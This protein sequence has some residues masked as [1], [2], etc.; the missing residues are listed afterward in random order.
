MGHLKSHNITYLTGRR[1]LG[2]LALMVIATVM[3]L[4]SC[5][6]TRI[7]QDGEYRLAKNKVRITNDKSFNPS[8]ITPYIKQAPNSY[9][10]GGWNPFLSVWNWQNGKGKGWDKFVKK[11]GVEPVIFDSTMVASSESNITK[12]LEYLG[13]Y[14]SQVTS[15]IIRK[16][17]KVNVEYDVTLGKRYPIKSISI[18]VPDE[19]LREHLLKDSADMMI[20]P[21][22]WLSE[23]LL[24]EETA[25]SAA[26]LRNEGF[27]GFNKNYYFFEADTLACRDSAILN[28]TVENY[29]RNESPS[30]AKPHNKFRINE[31]T[32][33]YPENLKIRN[34]LL[35]NLNTLKPG[36]LYN[37]KNVANTY[38]RLSS[39][40]MFNSVN[41]EMTQ[42]GDSLVDCAI[43]LTPSKMQGF[44]VNAEASVNSTGLIGISP[45]LNY[46]HK[47]IFH[48]GEW[49]NLGFM[50]NF[51]F[52]V[53][54]KVH[55]NEF[56]VSAGISFPRFLT[57]PS[58]FFKGASL[59][60]T[61]IN[62]SYNY[63]SRPE[64][65]RNMISAAYG[66]QGNLKSKFFYQLYPVQLNIVNLHNLD[67]SFFNS[68]KDD[69]FMRN[70]YQNH[71]DLG[72]GGNLY[73]TTNADVKP[74]SSFFYARL[75]LDLAG[76]FL[77]AF[78]KLMDKNESG[79]GMIWNTPYSQFVRTEV[80]V[81]KTWIFGHNKNQSIA[82]RLTAGVGYSYGNSKALPF[83]KHFYVGGA[84]SLRGWQARNVGP[85]LSQR[86]TTFIIP[87][88]T[89]DV[90]LEANIEYR[91][92]LF[93]KFAGALFVDAGN[94]WM[95][96]E[97]SQDPLYSTALTAKNFG[98]SL[99]ANWGLGIRLDLGFLLLRLDTGFKIHD[100]S[101]Q[102]KWLNL[103]DMFRHDGYSLHFGVGYPF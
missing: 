69:P 24:E 40:R 47:N 4:G 75:Q 94:V 55:S 103:K 3:T 41:V 81:G 52:K 33:E 82:T 50:G 71:F 78:K 5:S 19:R 26:K 20:K 6:T 90:K 31:I 96:K 77:S 34:S 53:K 43:S 49:L 91:F 88:Q 10:I 32:I 80:T 98:E 37:E 101:R 65:T 23:S 29:T 66:H 64:Y 14:D 18:N 42:N 44:K 87:N 89:G 92:K 60:R 54:D 36:Q 1:R 11:I 46:Y 28:L 21:G 102:H 48:G 51:Q 30:E 100:P 15:R 59:P 27:Y 35:Y 22:S 9:F 85:G 58:K 61:D 2:S 73:Y 86:D 38:S 56:G 70:A 67:Q 76:N 57:I 74:E 62:I 17:K 99:A 25:R 95:L 97:T 8:S 83:E 84:S 13:Y 7:L 12:R 39:I 45:Q 16:K 93:W 68:I 79:S 63:Q 72:V